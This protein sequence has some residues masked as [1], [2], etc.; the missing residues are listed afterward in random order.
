MVKSSAYAWRQ[1]VFYLS[2]VETEEL[3]E[4]L[5]WMRTHLSIQ[6]PEFQHRF[7]PAFDGLVA[8]SEGRTPHHADANRND[9]RQFLGWSKSRHWLM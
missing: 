8:A 9:G 7:Q 6:Q 5:D 1:M 2:F 4:F 3:R